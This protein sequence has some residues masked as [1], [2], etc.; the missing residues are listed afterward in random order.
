MIVTELENINEVVLSG[1]GT[2]I[3]VVVATIA[4]VFGQEPVIKPE[5]DVSCGA[6]LECMILSE[7]VTDFEITDISNTPVRVSWDGK[8]HGQ[9]VVFPEIQTLPAEHTLTLH[10]SE[11]FNIKLDYAE[12]TFN[13]DPFIGKWDGLCKPPES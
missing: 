3:P 13:A 7:S 4:K 1:D 8:E 5:T 9:V 10:A 6:A 12:S 2:R 11:P